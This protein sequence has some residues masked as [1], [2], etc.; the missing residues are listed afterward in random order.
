MIIPAF[1][2]IFYALAA[3][4]SWGGGDFCGGFAAKKTNQ[5][6][7]VTLSTASGISV[8]LICA[9]I[10]REQFP[11]LRDAIWAA[12]AGVVGGI[13]ILCLYR[14]LSFGHVASVAP[15]ASVLGAGIPAVFGAV[16]LGLPG[17]SKLGGFAL[18]LVGIWLV[19][20]AHKDSGKPSVIE[21]A[22]TVT[23]GVGFGGFFIL[24]S[25]I[26]AAEVFSP[27]FIARVF[28]L[29]T[30]L[31]LLISKRIPLP[32]I[33][34]QPLALVAGVL[35]AGGNIFYMFAR[36]FTRMDIAAVLSSVYPAITV[37]LASLILKEKIGRTQWFGLVCCVAAIM[38][39]SV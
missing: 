29:I 22:L 30:V 38:L 27:L 28:S 6:Q 24:I 17:V 3:A 34:S 19:S 15:V 2:G 31:G 11:G 26:S 20:R 13:G 4:I 25:Q 21:M 8:L 9:F 37:I 18:A 39:I 33:N 32:G 5:F 16:T 12:A 7:V 14:A 36:Q 23:A 10:T 35:D 1:A